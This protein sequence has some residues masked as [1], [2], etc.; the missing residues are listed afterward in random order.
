MKEW[1]GKIVILLL[2]I[3]PVMVHAEEKSEKA[4]G[5][6]FSLYPAIEGKLGDKNCKDFYGRCML[7]QM[8]KPVLELTNF[9][10]KLSPRRTPSDH[11]QINIV[12]TKKQSADFEKVS[13][14]YSG[15]GKRLAIVFENKILHAPKLKSKIKTDVL[16]IDFCN[17][18]LYQ[19]LS[20]ILRGKIPSN[21][22]FAEDNMCKTCNEPSGE[23]V[24]R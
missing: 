17:D 12:L 18:H 21:Y 9:Y 3:I 2:V 20:D 11:S 15:N 6:T 19:I 22:N 7:Y 1:L 14:K 16:V 13:E 5:K 24:V 23:G 8:D 4:Q 10:F